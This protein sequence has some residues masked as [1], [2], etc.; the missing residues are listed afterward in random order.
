MNHI[1]SIQII[2]VIKVFIAF[3]FGLGIAGVGFAQSSAAWPAGGAL[4]HTTITNPDDPNSEIY[5]DW[6][7]T[8]RDGVTHTFAGQTSANPHYIYYVDQDPKLTGISYTSLN[9]TSSDGAYILSAKGGSGSVSIVGR[10]TTKYTV[11]GVIYSPPGARS[12]VQFNKSQELG[13]TRNT[14]KSWS[15]TIN[16]TANFEAGLIVASG[17]LSITGSWTNSHKDS[18]TTSLTTSS[19]SG[20][21]WN[22]AN[23]GINHDNDIIIVWLN[24]QIK[25]TAS[26]L[27]NPLLATVSQDFESNQAFGKAQIDAGQPVDINVMDLAF[28]TVAELRNPSIMSP[29]GNGKKI[30]REWAG[31]GGLVQADFDS[32]L[33]YDPYWN[34]NNF[35]TPAS[36]GSRFTWV[37]TIPYLPNNTTSGFDKNKYSNTKSTTNSQTETVGITWTASAGISKFFEAGSKISYSLSWGQE[38][39]DTATQTNDIQT[40]FSIVGPSSS[41]WQGPNSVNV[42]RD[43]LFGT[44]MFMYAM[45]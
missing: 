6:A 5:T 29:D 7:W 24:P 21:T 32:I 15:N 12:N 14:S 28:L 40:S 35:P 23:D 8:D 25:V 2:K 3:I 42:Y 34:P 19:G 11:L 30:K 18:I 26:N 45:Q 44:Y 38:H 20:S 33:S 41:T 4:T 43:N 16:A 13:V 39:T 17:A 36:L 31:D 10:A 37:T 27:Q 22:G 1:A 9:A